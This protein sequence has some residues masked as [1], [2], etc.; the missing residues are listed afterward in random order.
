MSQMVSSSQ[1]RFQQ[2]LSSVSTMPSSNLLLTSMIILLSILFAITLYLVVRLETLQTK[3][4][5]SPQLKHSPMEQ[6]VEWQSILQSQSS[7]KI[8]E[9][10]DINLQQIAKVGV[11][12][13]RF[14]SPFDW[15]LCYVSV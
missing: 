6:I 10:L 14:S 11:Y 12:L 9:Y 1:S 15:Y 13:H 3:M 4:E 5:S 2:M 7:K 8:Q